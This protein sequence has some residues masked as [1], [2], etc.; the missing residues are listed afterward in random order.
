MKKKIFLILITL[1]IFLSFKIP[2]KQKN[3][4]NYEKFLITYDINDDYITRIEK[5]NCFASSMGAEIKEVR[6]ILES[7]NTEVVVL[8]NF[9]KIGTV[10]VLNNSDPDHSLPEPSDVEGSTEF[11]RR[12]QRASAFCGVIVQSRHTP[13][14]M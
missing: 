7:A 10:D 4:H 9:S 8:Y 2:T 3:N 13:N 14:I 1:T 11:Y 5:R 6:L 12:I